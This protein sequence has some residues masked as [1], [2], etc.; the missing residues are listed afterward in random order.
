[1][2]ASA[3]GRPRDK[4]SVRERVLVPIVNGANEIRAEPGIAPPPKVSLALASVQLD[5]LVDLSLVRIVVGDDGGDK[6]DR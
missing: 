3:S 5:P 1:M 2:F 4:D 6:V